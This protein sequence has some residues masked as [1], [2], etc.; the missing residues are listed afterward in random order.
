MQK[1]DPRAKRIAA[2]RRVACKTRQTALR[3][4]AKAT[5]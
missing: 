4:H 5:Q 1:S 3:Q 2:E